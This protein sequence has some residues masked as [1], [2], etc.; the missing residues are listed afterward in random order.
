MIEE[1]VDLY[2]YFGAERKGATRGYL[3]CLR[4]EGLP[5]M[6]RALL[7][8]AMLVIP[9]GGYV[10]V[11]QR[12]GWP[13]ALTF[14]GAGYETFTLEYDV[15]PVSYPAQIEQAAMAMAYIRRNAQAFGILPDKVAAIG[16]SAGGH[17]LGCISA[18]WDDPA[19]AAV[20]GDACAA[21]RPDASVYG[22]PVV[23]A[24]ECE[25]EESF[26]NFCRKAVKAETYSIERR[27]RP[28]C[29]PAFI[30]AN[31][32]DSV[33][34]VQNALCLYEA[35]LQA[36]VPVELHIFRDGWH[37][38][39]VCTEETEPSVPIRPECAYVRPWVDLCRNFLKTLG[40]AVQTE[41]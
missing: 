30:W 36:G 18:I 16:F 32:P 4:H 39:T 9:G 25:H 13:V 19:I 20:L 41:R 5:E 28:E 10:V 22:Y 12:E 29:S 31:T 33:V 34:P 17:L 3:R 7:R 6:G 1:T 26:E 2:D 24:G 23:T 14:F 35:Y 8:P 15:A 27:V 38:M 11:S 21:A 40:F 37:G